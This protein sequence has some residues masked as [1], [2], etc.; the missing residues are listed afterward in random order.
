[1]LFCN[2]LD[3]PPEIQNNC[4]FIL[5]RFL[6]NSHCILKKK[7]FLMQAYMYKLFEKCS[8]QLLFRLQTIRNRLIK[9]SYVLSFYSILSLSFIDFLSFFLPF[10]RFIYL[11]MKSS[12]H[13]EFSWI[14]FSYINSWLLNYY[15]SCC[16]H[17]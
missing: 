5:I 13:F 15:N 10:F 1:M 14:S 17:H 6:N 9:T 3:I 7:F 2:K 11:N 16:I 8:L 12:M 4:S